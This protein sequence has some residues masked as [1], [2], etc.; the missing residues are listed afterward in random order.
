VPHINWQT[1]VAHLL[2]DHTRHLGYRLHVAP[3]FGHRQIC[4]VKPS[5][6][7]AWIGQLSERFEPSTVIASFL[8]LQSILDLA[9]ADEAIKKNP[10]KSPVVQTPVHQAP[11]I[12]VW[13]DEVIAF[14]IDA[15]PDSL[16]AVPELAASCGMREGE[17]FG[18]A[19]EDFD[20]GEKVVRVRRQV[21]RLG[22]TYVFALPKNDS[23]RIIPLSDWDIGA[24]RRHAEKYPPRPYTLPWE[25]PGGSRIRAASCSAGPRTTSTS[26]LVA[27]RR[28]SGSPP[29]L[30][31]A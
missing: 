14:L 27:T 3:A 26:R 13:A 2:S 4:A 17:L 31:L 24:V 21:K 23:E 1:C 22:S 28:W 8:A 16:R 15:H 29:W 20:Y 7:Q 25:K 19:L 12:Q 9:V 11:E 10:A 5:R 18:I 30:R 6:I